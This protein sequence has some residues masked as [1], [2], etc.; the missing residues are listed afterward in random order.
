MLFV[1]LV[2]LIFA[3]NVDATYGVTKLGPCTAQ[4]D[5]GRIIDLSKNKWLNIFIIRISFIFFTFC[6]YCSAKLDNAKSPR[7]VFSS[8]FVFIFSFDF[9]SYFKRNVTSGDFTY[10]YNP[11]SSFLCGPYDSAV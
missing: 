6:L 10:K 1:S 9:Y 8:H 2:V 3:L 11:C 5:D 7:Y 4:L